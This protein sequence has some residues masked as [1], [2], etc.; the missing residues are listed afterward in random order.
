M[1]LRAKPALEAVLRENS[2]WM[3]NAR[4]LQIA[5]AVGTALVKIDK[6]KMEAERKAQAAAD[7]AA[8]MSA[9]T[10]ASLPRSTPAPMSAVPEDV[11]DTETE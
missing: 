5:Q 11:P 3:A 10:A 2:G 6:D 8:A 7:N 1:I 9:G 4:K